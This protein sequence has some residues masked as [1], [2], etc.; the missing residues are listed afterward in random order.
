MRAAFSLWIALCAVACT[1]DVWDPA[2]LGEG[3]A[4]SNART[5]ALGRE[6]YGQYCVGC[7]GDSGDGNGLAARFL[8]PKPRDLR[9]GKL[10]FAGVA[11]G[12][13]PR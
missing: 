3:Q 12:D 1:G 6:L 4:S 9:L 7:H 2:E 13:P 11:S 5:V 10:K 8:D